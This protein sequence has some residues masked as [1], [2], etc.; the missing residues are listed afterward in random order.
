MPRNKKKVPNYGKRYRYHP[1]HVKS[2]RYFCARSNLF[3]FQQRALQWLNTKRHHDISEEWHGANN[4]S[5]GAI[6]NVEYGLGKTMMSLYHAKHTKWKVLYLCPPNIVSHIQQEITKHFGSSVVCHELKKWNCFG[7]DDYDIVILS[8]YTLSRLDAD[9]VRANNYMFNTCIVDELEDAIQKKGVR[10]A[11]QEMLQARY[12]LGLTG[13]NKIHPLMLRLLRCVKDQKDVFTFRQPAPFL[14]TTQFL[15]RESWDTTTIDEYAFIEKTIKTKTGL[16][17]E[18]MLDRA[19]E[20]VSHAKVD[21]VILMLSKICNYKVL[22]VSE[23]ASTLR[24]ISQKLKEYKQQHLCL[25]SAEAAT[26][27][28]RTQILQTFEQKESKMN[29][30]LAQLHIIVFGIDLG[31]IDFLIVVDLPMKLLEYRQLQGRCRRVG[32]RPFHRQVPEVIE[33]VTKK[34]CDWTLYSDIHNTKQYHI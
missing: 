15:S 11:I 30:L 32:Q 7:Y 1:Y 2:K 34:T 9:F 16:Q 5:N 31:F 8:F 17:A 20:I 28:K 27:T 3:R 21:H 23:F 13:A 6:L 19:R 10:T 33:I 26:Q 25:L 22:V 18:K 14:L 12:F 4:V 29:I 24:L